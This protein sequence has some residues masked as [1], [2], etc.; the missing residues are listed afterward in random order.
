MKKILLI[1]LSLMVLISCCLAEVT[2]KITSISNEETVVTFLNDDKEIAKQIIDGKTGKLIKTIGK[3]PDGI[4][5]RY[6]ENGNL[7]AESTW[8]NND[9]SGSAKLYYQDGKLMAEH[10]FKEGK[11]VGKRK[12]FDGQ[13]VL[14][15][16]VKGDTPEDPVKITGATDS[17]VGISA[18]YNY[19]NWMFGERNVD[20]KLN[21][22]Y[23]LNEKGKVF[24][25]MDIELADGTT[26]N[27]YFDISEFFGKLN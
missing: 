1:I 2:S 16:W 10:V 22:Q 8:K 3:I 12:Y 19:L 7:K 5:K 26:L 14:C 6:D 13:G 23:L 17:S 24:D 15:E 11:I 25:K 20:W 18:E 9:L 27:I 4:V 21:R